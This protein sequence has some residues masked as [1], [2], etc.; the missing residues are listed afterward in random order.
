MKGQVNEPREKGKLAMEERT[1]ERAAK[2]ELNVRMM[3]NEKG[4]THA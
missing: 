1:R 3:E 2:E 4:G